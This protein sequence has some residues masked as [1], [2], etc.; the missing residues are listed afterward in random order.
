M[1]L[2]EAL[3]HDV[4]KVHEQVDALL[5]REDGV[6]A[7]FDGA[8]VVTYASGFGVSASQLELLGVAVERALRDGVGR[9]SAGRGHKRRRHE[10]DPGPRSDAGVDRNDDGAVGRVLH[11]ARKTA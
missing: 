11:L 5:D 7:L 8:R 1:T 3:G 9:V 2:R 4:R 10:S 6:L